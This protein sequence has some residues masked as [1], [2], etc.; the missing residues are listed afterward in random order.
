MGTLTKL[1]TP[2]KE[3]PST[4]FFKVIL[5]RLEVVSVYVGGTTPITS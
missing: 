3:I 1:I 4:N 2:C 5:D